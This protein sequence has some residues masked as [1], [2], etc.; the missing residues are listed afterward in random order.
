VAGGWAAPLYVSQSSIF[1]TRSRTAHIRYQLYASNPKII[2]NP[3]YHVADEL[4]RSGHATRSQLLVQPCLRPHR[5]RLSLEAQCARERRGCIWLV[6]PSR[7]AAGADA[8]PTRCCI[9]A[10]SALAGR[11]IL[12]RELL[13]NASLVG[14]TRQKA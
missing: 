1:V 3:K 6:P 2:W 4:H 10:R 11:Y 5:L 12:G 13:N 7:A 8:N 9:R 14:D